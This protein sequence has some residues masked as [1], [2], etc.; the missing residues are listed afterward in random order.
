MTLADV[1]ADFPGKKVPSG[2]DGL[3]ICG[4]GRTSAGIFWGAVSILFKISKP[5]IIATIQDIIMAIFCEPTE[6]LFSISI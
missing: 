6:K 1:A 3:T 2:E 5:R 4:T